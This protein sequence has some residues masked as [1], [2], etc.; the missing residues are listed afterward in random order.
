MKLTPIL[1]LLYT[2]CACTLLLALTTGLF[3]GLFGWAHSSSDDKS[4]HCEALMSKL[5]FTKNECADHPFCYSEKGI[6]YNGLYPD[7][8]YHNHWNAHLGPKPHSPSG[9]FGATL[10]PCSECESYLDTL[11]LRCEFVQ[12][13]YSSKG[14]CS[15]EKNRCTACSKLKEDRCSR[16]RG[17][18]YYSAS[19]EIPDKGQC[20]TE[21]DYL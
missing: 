8:E 6:E 18:K 12:H 16:Q 1:A 19:A 5:V 2:S 14:D 15:C 11:P 10:K 21:S 9:S 13:G 17:C 4:L 20:I 3:A 7:H